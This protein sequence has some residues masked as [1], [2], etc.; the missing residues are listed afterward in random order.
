MDG[1][2]LKQAV[3]RVRLVCL[4]CRRPFCDSLAFTLLLVLM[5]V[6]CYRLLGFWAHQ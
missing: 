6:T 3:E 4:E 5:A 1:R 2:D